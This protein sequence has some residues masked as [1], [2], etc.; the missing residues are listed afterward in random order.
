MRLCEI[1]NFVMCSDETVITQWKLII[2]RKC[3]LFIRFF[4]SASALS[5]AMVDVI[6]VRTFR[7]ASDILFMRRGQ[8]QGVAQRLPPGRRAAGHALLI[9]MMMVNRHTDLRKLL[10]KIFSV[11]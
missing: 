7:L 2:L 8:G 10:T 5:F 4:L 3:D 1:N 6:I 11:D 9:M